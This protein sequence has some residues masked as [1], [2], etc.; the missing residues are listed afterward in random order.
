[1][2]ILLCSA[3]ESCCHFI[4]CGGM[5]Q[6]A[7]MLGHLLH[8]STAYVLVL[9]GAVDIATQHAIGCEGFLGWWPREDENVPTS[10]SEG[11]S[12]LLK[13]LFTK[14]RHDVASLATNILQRLRFYE[15]ASKYEVSVHFLEAV[16]MFMHMF[17]NLMTR[18][19]CLAV[20]S[21]IR[22]GKTFCEWTH[23]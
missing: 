14:Q 22:I 4:N 2:V 7:A 5:E 3:R 21:I 13:L 20:S 11:Y 16:L 17:D 1:M 12:N 18:L 9:L 15:S 6:L 23:C 19:V 8:G 10:N